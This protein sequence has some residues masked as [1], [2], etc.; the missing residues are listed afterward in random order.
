MCYKSLTAKFR[1][2]DL[3]LSVMEKS[4]KVKKRSDQIYTVKFRFLDGETGVGR[5]SWKQ[6]V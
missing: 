2:L 1:G 3:I 4:C 6:E 5:K